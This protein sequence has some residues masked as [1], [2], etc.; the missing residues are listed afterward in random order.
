MSMLHPLY[1]FRLACRILLRLT[2]MVGKF[3]VSQPGSLGRR[4]KAARPQR[5]RNP[6]DG[7]G[8]HERR[9][10]VPDRWRPG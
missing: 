5:Q 10:Q 3:M 8:G 9:W 7:A 2:V 1:P 6:T 4:P